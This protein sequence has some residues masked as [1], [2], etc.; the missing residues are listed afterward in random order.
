MYELLMKWL[1]LHAIHFQTRYA[2]KI[3]DRLAF[4]LLMHIPLR[5]QRHI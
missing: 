1:F 5:R 3:H 2:S 4:W